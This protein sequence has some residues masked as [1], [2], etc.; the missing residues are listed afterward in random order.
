[1]LSY[2]SDFDFYAK[3]RLHFFPISRHKNFIHTSKD[4]SNEALSSSPKTPSSL[5]MFVVHLYYSINLNLN[6]S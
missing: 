6:L 2:Q 1:M 5:F 3:S 4:L